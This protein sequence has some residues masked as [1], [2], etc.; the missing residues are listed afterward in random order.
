MRLCSGDA[1]VATHESIVHDGVPG[2]CP[3]C[4]SNQSLLE[5]L[6]EVS[7]LEGRVEQLEGE[8]R[9]RDHQLY[10]VQPKGGPA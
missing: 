5:A 3:L 2:S 9:A 7:R 8:M 1:Y 10:L 6:A 4:A